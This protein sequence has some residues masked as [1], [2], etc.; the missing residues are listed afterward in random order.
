MESYYFLCS[1]RMHLIYALLNFRFHYSLEAQWEAA[2]IEQC[3]WHI[4]VNLTE[5]RL[6][7]KV[8]NIILIQLSWNKYN[9]EYNNANGF[10]FTTMDYIPKEQIAVS[11]QCREQGMAHPNRDGIC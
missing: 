7:T 1:W 4:W 2:K 6:W 3:Q 11:R 9:N 8:T 5:F 10:S